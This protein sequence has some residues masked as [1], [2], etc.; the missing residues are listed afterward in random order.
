[1]HTHL[2]FPAFSRSWYFEMY[3]GLVYYGNVSMKRLSSHFQHLPFYFVTLQ[4]A[5]Y[6]IA[7]DRVVR[8]NRGETDCLLVLKK[9]STMLWKQFIYIFLRIWFE[10]LYLRQYQELGWLRGHQERIHL[11]SH[12][13]SLR[14]NKRRRQKRR[15][16]SWRVCEKVLNRRSVLSHRK[17]RRV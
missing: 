7:N 17:G 14:Q 1:M 9:S 15:S 16:V 11:P 2:Y 12:C 13:Q 4:S 3:K 5:K 8:S 10:V 6:Y